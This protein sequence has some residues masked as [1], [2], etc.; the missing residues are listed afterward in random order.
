LAWN[1]YTWVNV[2]YGYGG[3]PYGYY[4]YSYW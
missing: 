1:G 4:S 3:Y 2:C